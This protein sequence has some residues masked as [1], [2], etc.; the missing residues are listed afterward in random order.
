MTTSRFEVL[1]STV[2]A[3]FIARRSYGARWRLQHGFTLIEL[4]ITMVIIGILASIAYPAYTGYVQDA[5]RADGKAGLMETAQQ[6][7]QCYTRQSSYVDCASVTFPTLSPDG[8]Y[9]IDVS[10]DDGGSLSA[11]EYK[12]VAIPQGT[13]ASDACGKLTLMQTGERGS[14]GGGDDCW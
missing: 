14:A 1:P 8:Y 11:T 3:D 7:E 10:E 6:L 12:L 13:Q 9:S 4:M 5:R 2:A